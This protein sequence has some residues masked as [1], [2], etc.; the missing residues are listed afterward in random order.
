MASDATAAAERSQIPS[1]KSPQEA[2][3]LSELRD[4]MT[5]NSAQLSPVPR[6]LKMATLVTLHSC[7]RHLGIFPSEDI[8]TFND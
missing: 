8:A 4:C 5:S 7:R 3:M 1:R 6:N 2:R